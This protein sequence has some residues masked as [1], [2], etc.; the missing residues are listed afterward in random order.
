MHLF[1]WRCL[2]TVQCSVPASHTKCWQ[3]PL[4]FGVTLLHSLSDGLPS[5]PLSIQWW[6]MTWSPPVLCSLSHL[7]HLTVSNSATPISS[8]FH[9]STYFLTFSPLLFALVLPQNLL[10]NPKQ[11]KSLTLKRDCLALGTSAV[12]EAKPLSLSLSEMQSLS[13][14]VWISAKATDAAP[15]LILDFHSHV[16]GIQSWSHVGWHNI[17]T[18][19]LHLYLNILYIYVAFP[20]WASTCSHGA[21]L[22]QLYAYMWSLNDSD[23][24]LTS[25]EGLIAESDVGIQTCHLSCAWKDDKSRI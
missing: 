14:S 19:Y 23:I 21:T 11:G 10:F 24:L 4:S 17:S 25:F 15:Q 8:L 9:T 6:N 2:W 1:V 18:K 20:C 13:F 12:S 22:R 7:F 16:F 5:S 3:S